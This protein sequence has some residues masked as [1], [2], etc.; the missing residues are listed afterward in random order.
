MNKAEV[1]ALLGLPDDSPALAPIEDI[2]ET[3]A[4]AESLPDLAIAVCAMRM[5]E[6]APAFHALLARAADGEDLPEDHAQLLFYGIY[7]LGAAKDQAAC[8]PLLRLLH[9]P[10][11]EID[12]L[13]G[14]AVTQSLPRIFVGVFDGDADAL[15]GT[16]A[17]PA[18]DEFIREA[19]FSA[20]TFLTWEGRIE[21]DR[22]RAFLERFHQEPLAE[23]EEFVW[24]GWLG[25]I[26]RLGLRDMAPLVHAA[27]D[28]GRIPDGIMERGDFEKD[29]AEAERAPG[30]G[31]RFA[32][33]NVGYIEDVL[34]EL[35]WTRGMARQDNDENEE[36][37]AAEDWQ[38]PAEPVKNPLR[39]VGRNDPC[40]C[41]SGKK[42][43]KCCLPA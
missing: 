24:I 7:M 28:A 22:M 33:A 21:R 4:T 42:F 3:M 37:L 11:K 19:L 1:A 6:A 39:H 35:S 31:E 32:R 25:A 13:L 38:P 30:D 40:P 10:E 12:H 27:W 36:M 8:Q 14:D 17:D 41:G 26:A 5:E 18:I 34:E 9:R 20:A 16:I 43:K 15:F 23:D 29:L 2:L